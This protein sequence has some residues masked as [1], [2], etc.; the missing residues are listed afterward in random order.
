MLGEAF[1]PASFRYSVV[2]EL[3]PVITDER[4][5]VN[6]ICSFKARAAFDKSTQRNFHAHR[7][8][9]RGRV[10]L[11]EYDRRCFFLFL[12]FQN[13]GGKEWPT[14]REQLTYFHDDSASIS[15][16]EWGAVGRILSVPRNDYVGN[17]SLLV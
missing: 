3:L 12:G 17:L 2:D 11:K 16:R 5:Q 1:I 15:K 9:E 6:G 10:H 4:V 14:L 7:D 8:V 13:R